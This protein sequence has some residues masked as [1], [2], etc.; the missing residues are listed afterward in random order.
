MADRHGSPR[1]ELQCGPI[2]FHGPPNQPRQ[3][4]GQR[5][6]VSAL[7]VGATGCEPVT[8]SV[9]GIR[10]AARRPAANGRVCS[11]SWAVAC[12][13]VTGVVRCDPVVRGPDVAPMWPSGPEL[14]RRVRALSSAGMLHRSCSSVCLPTDRCC[15]WETVRDRCYGHVEGTA[16]RGRRWLRP[17]GNGHQLDRR[18]RP[19][20]GDH[21][22]RWQVAGGR[23][24]SVVAYI[25]VA[26]G[27]V[28]ISGR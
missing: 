22:P 20:L 27:F 23:R 24:G 8:S 14:G 17:C 9:S 26:A 3:H 25:V 10:G 21:L 19:A 11:V 1:H 18:V 13:M 28:T 15:P 12:P 6:P 2:R 5:S 16:R 4:A 7:M